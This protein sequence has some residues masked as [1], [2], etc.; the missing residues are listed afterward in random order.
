MNHGEFASDR[1]HISSVYLSNRKAWDT[2]LGRLLL[3]LL[4]AILVFAPIG[5]GA[6]PAAPFLVVQGLVIAVL[7]VWGVRL[8]ISPRPQLLWPPICWV[9]LAF[10]VYA[11]GRYLT[12]D[13]EYVARQ[14]M[15]QV[16]VLGGIFFA[17]LNHLY[18]QE[19]AQGVVFTLVAT[20]TAISFLAIY[21]YLHHTRTIWGYSS[22]YPGRAFGTYVSPNNFACFLELLIPPALAFMVAGR[23][24]PQYRALLAAALVLMGA[25]LVVSFSRGGWLA[26]GAGVVT[27]LVLLATH[28]H[29]RVISILLL[30]LIGGGV[31]YL[32]YR[33]FG[34]VADTNHEPWSAGVFLASQRDLIMRLDMWSAAANMWR[35]H[36][37]FGAGPAHYN[38]LFDQYRPERMQLQPDR[39][40]ND[41]LNLLADWGVAGG[42]IVLAGLVA[43]V[44]GLI[45]A[46]PHIQRA[47][48]DFN[49]GF[50]NR[51]AFYV[52]ASG[53]LLALT[54]HSLMDFNLHI[55]ANAA[56]ALTW[57]ALLSSNQRFATERWWVNVRAGL[58]WGV[59]ALLLVMMAYLS[60]Q[61]WRRSQETR[62]LARAEGQSPSSVERA[63]CLEQ[64]I[65]A[66]PKNFQTYYDLAEIWRV[67]CFIESE[68]YQ[69]LADQA[70]QRYQQS[71][72]LNPHFTYNYLRTGM[73]LDWLGRHAEAQPFFSQAE[74]T[75]PNN[76]QIVACIGWHYALV[77]DYGA[78]RQWFLRSLQLDSVNNATAGRYM[79][80]MDERLKEDSPPNREF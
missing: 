6:V 48:A 41:Y 77:R 26:T 8:W 31:A 67:N 63:A 34:Q 69:Q 19:S 33:H 32:G 16:L 47:E 4:L 10:M 15:I 51:F 24:A 27:V 14:E 30:L 9:V 66:E 23:L 52:G 54:L 73:C 78:A 12:A 25:G 22:P 18:R 40:H 80:L 11:V 49:S 36:F 17:I 42:L 79:M 38:S 68:N 59:T 43:L 56:L 76:S 28:R 3:G 70:L 21:Q 57:L 75:A 35:D 37:W 71:R 64:A 65:A 39:A 74:A 60:W 20:A 62:W 55:P 1:K 53:A 61:G 2:G 44:A 13:I 29:L 5:L 50:S 45:K 72:E 58:K 7:L 46:W